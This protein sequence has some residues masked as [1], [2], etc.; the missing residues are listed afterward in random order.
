[1]RGTALS[2]EK[3]GFAI[4]MLVVASLTILLGAQQ[5]HAHGTAWPNYGGKYPYHQSSYASCN[6][7][8]NRVLAYTPSVVKSYYAKWEKAYWVTEL[9]RYSNGAWR[10]YQYYP[11][12]EQATVSRYGIEK[13]YFY[14]SY[15]Y[16]YHY[17]PTPALTFAEVYNS[18]P[19]G[20]YS[21]K[22]YYDWDNNPYAAHKQ[23]QYFQNGST[24]CRIT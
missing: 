19:R 5:A 9:Y 3:L 12:A 18:L 6:D 2:L 24:V 15:A 4:C 21:V 7:A 17:W 16:W 20:Y 1:M 13:T 11:Y 14:G 23:W 10:L 8:N 22:Q